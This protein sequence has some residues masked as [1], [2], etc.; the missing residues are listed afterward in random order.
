MEDHV[1]DIGSNRDPAQFTETQKALSNY[2]IREVKHGGNDL[3][4]AILKLELPDIAPR[5]MLS[6]T[7]FDA[8]HAIEQK[9]WYSEYQRET[10]READYEKGS[11]KVMAYID[12]ITTP[13][14]ETRLQGE[15]GYQ[16]A[17]DNQD[18]VAYLKIIEAVM[19]GHKSK[20]HPVLAMHEAKRTFYV[21]FQ[22]ADEPLDKY[23]DVFNAQA[24]VLDSIGGEIGSDPSLI[25]RALEAAGVAVTN[26]ATTRTESA[27]A[28]Q[29]REARKAAKEGVLAMALLCSVY[30]PRYGELLDDLANDYA[31][32]DDRYPKTR[33]DAIALITNFQ[34]TV[35]KQQERARAKDKAAN[36]EDVALLNDG[37]AGGLTKEQLRAE[38]RCYFCGDKGH[39]ARNCPKK[40]KNKSKSKQQGEVGMN[41]D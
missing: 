21:G 9:I 24:K 27:S 7:D 32:G 15:E 1:F 8:M 36:A 14:L 28:A 2:V 34:P 12:C 20:K 31:K 35:K 13:K 33:A 25:E 6:S 17:K 16:D 5:T 39:L 26:G 3:G 22:R 41:L 40:D 10:E 38:G 11:P 29:L 4:S 19:C 23:S 37:G 18:V 30:R